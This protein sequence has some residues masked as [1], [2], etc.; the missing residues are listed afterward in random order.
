MSDLV[1]QLCYVLEVLVNM[2]SY[3]SPS[4]EHFCHTVTAY[5]RSHLHSQ[6]RVVENL[7]LVFP[8]KQ[9]LLDRFLHRCTLI[10]SKYEALFFLW[11]MFAV[12]TSVLVHRL[13]FLRKQWPFN[14]ILL[15][16]VV[17]QSVFVRHSEILSHC[18]FYN[19]QFSILTFLLQI[20]AHLPKKVSLYL[21][22]W[23]CA[24][25]LWTFLKFYFV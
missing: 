23:I 11:L 10:S 16:Y 3:V 21:S 8:L 5:N 24:K 25:I 6:E 4:L 14:V 1:S 22:C 12:F 18:R 20:W 17:F 13:P 7:V 19:Y 9:Q 15:G 2:C